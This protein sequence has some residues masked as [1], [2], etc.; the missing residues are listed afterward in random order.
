MRIYEDFFILNLDCGPIV[1]V[2]IFYLERF[3]K[4]TQQM[5]E[6][7]NKFIQDNENLETLSWIITTLPS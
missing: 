7:I 3:P 1:L 5:E 6:K 4:A 2:N